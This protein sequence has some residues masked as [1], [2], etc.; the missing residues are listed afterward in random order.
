MGRKCP[1]YAACF[2]YQARRRMSH[3]QILVVNHA[4]YFTD[5]ALR[6]QGMGMLPRHDIVIFDEAHTLEAVAGD[7]LGLRLTNGQVE[8]TLR[9]LYNDRTNKG[10][11]ARPG[12]REAQEQVIDCYHRAHRY[13][14]DIDQWLAG[15]K[16]GNGRVRRAADRRESR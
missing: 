7:H 12:F 8:F 16:G 4:L 13:F 11:L 6:M 10:L 5:L 9:R 14:E 15:Q 3:A 2:Y 1:T